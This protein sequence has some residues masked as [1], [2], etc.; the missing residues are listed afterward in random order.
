M[1]NLHHNVSSVLDGKAGVG[2]FA[3]RFLHKGMVIAPLLTVLPL[4]R[5]SMSMDGIN[6]PTCPAN[7]VEGLPRY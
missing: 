5:Q 2:A 6:A 1:D 4:L 3:S 7:A